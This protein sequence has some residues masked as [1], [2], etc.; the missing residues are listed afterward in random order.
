MTDTLEPDL[1]LS[2]EQHAR[3][4]DQIIDRV[5]ARTA[6]V[7]EGRPVAVILAG[8]PGAGKSGLCTQ[9]REDL[10]ERGAVEVDV[11]ALRRYHPQY[12]DFLAQDDLSAAPRTQRNAS[13]WADELRDAAIVGRRNLIIDGTLKNPDNAERLCERLRESGYQVEV[14]ALAVAPENSRLGVYLRYE[15]A[16]AKAGAGRWVPERVHDEAV[17]GMP[18]SLRCIEQHG[19][20]DR[21]QVY[22]R[23]S[24]QAIY[25]NAAALQGGIDGAAK[26]VAAEH[27]REPTFD[28]HRDGVDGWR[29]WHALAEM[30]GHLDKPYAQRGLDL[31]ARAQV[32]SLDAQCEAVIASGERDTPD[33]QRLF[34]QRAKAHRENLPAFDAAAPDRSSKGKDLGADRSAGRTLDRD[35]R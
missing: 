35:D 32:A 24:N 3:I 16:H 15:D 21:V 23:G 17:A 27:C 29:Q 6:A 10:R 25:D 18:E 11:D 26:V 8:Q 5:L 2:P 28:E 14:R 13:R 12:A 4:R 7:H 30:N 1:D 33:A 22:H 20:A 31:E 9:A 19:L 34:A